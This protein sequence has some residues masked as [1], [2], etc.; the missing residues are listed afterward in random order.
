[1]SGG[2]ASTAAGPKRVVI[3]IESLRRGG[4]ERLLLTTLNQLDRDRVLPLVVTLFDPNPLAS[5]IRDLGIDVVELGLRGPRD[6][7][8]GVLQIRRVL[9]EF[10][11]D[12]L[13]THLF[14]ANIA[15][16]FASVGLC[17]VVTTLHNPDYGSE[18]PGG[19]FGLRK[20]LD[21]LSSS[22]VPTTF[23]AVS[24]D[25]RADYTEHLG[26]DD[27]HVVPNYIDVTGFREEVRSVDRS[28]ARA[29]FQ[30]PKGSQVVLHVGRFHPQ[31]DQETLVRAFALLQREVPRAHLVLA[32]SGPDRGRIEALVTSLLLQDSV[33]FTGAVAEVAALYRAADVFCFPSRY[34]AFGIALL[35]AMAAGVPAVASDVGGIREV[36]GDGGAVLVPPGSPERFAESL[37]DLLT[38]EADWQK[39]SESGMWR[40]RYFDAR[41]RIAEVEALYA[42]A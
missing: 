3:A 1:M 37:R 21:R 29:R 22:L 20:K 32:G 28:E 9:R 41:E 30:I 23:L 42:G 17:P 26:L 31:K 6:L 36:A 35:E 11:A 5:D 24:E 27:I 34:E 8:R 15:G 19:F 2:T 39:A 38:G 12:L 13:H 16:R 14:T 7:I 25:V 18:G 40:A 4:A 33:T 10:D